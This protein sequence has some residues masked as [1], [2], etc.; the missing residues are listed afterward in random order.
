[1]PEFN[2]PKVINDTFGNPRPYEPYVKWLEGRLAELEDQLV[3]SKGVITGL[4]CQVMSYA[5]R[6][7]RR[8]QYESDYVQQHDDNEGRE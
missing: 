4:H 7:S 1:V 3:R 6:E 2:G 5:Q 8:F